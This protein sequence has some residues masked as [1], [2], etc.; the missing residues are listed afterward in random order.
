MTHVDRLRE[1]E[2][3]QSMK[4]WGEGA[5]LICFSFGW[6][7]QC[8]SLQNPA[9]KLVCTLMYV[10][11]FTNTKANRTN[12]DP[13]LES[14]V[15]KKESGVCAKFLLF[16]LPRRP[17]SGC[18]HRICAKRSSLWVSHCGDAA[19]RLG[20]ELH[21]RGQGF[22]WSYRLMDEQGEL[23]RATVRAHKKSDQMTIP[24]PYS[25]T[26]FGHS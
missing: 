7:L 23:P 12:A 13:L 4:T 5:A 15:D 10:L 6:W 25:S 17:T 21:R 1:E 22:T 8:I 20:E 11:Y 16:S 9:K 2:W 14:E 19:S 18:V 3:V 26:V 24:G